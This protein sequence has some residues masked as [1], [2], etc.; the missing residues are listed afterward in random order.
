MC[1]S[2]S[3][4]MF[5]VYKIKECAMKSM[6]LFLMVL[7]Y[8]LLAFHENFNGQRVRTFLIDMLLDNVK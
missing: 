2:C 3:A 1:T 5:Y 7:N 8:E 4:I 6:K